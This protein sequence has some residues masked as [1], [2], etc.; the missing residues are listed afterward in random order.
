LE[1]EKSKR[2]KQSVTATFAALPRKKQTGPRKNSCPS[3][4]LSKT[5]A[6][7]QGVIVTIPIIG[8]FCNFHKFYFANKQHY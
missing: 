3:H 1:E 7:H 8:D 5:E 6:L 4:L 2:L